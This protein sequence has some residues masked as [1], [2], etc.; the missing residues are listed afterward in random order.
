[1]VLFLIRM[2]QEKRCHFVIEQ[3]ALHAVCKVAWGFLKSPVAGDGF[4]EQGKGFG[5]DL[6]IPIGI[7]NEQK[8]F[9]HVAEPI[10]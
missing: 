6:L 3:T 10:G 5:Q 2:A 1:M 4:A 7:G 9:A 8:V